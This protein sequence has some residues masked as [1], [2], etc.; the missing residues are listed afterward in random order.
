MSTT[1]SSPPASRP[2]FLF[3]T[4]AWKDYREQRAIWLAI[5]VL[6]VVLSL[7]IGAFAQ[8]ASRSLNMICSLLGRLSASA[9]W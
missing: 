6:A 8:A 9:C 4:L 3:K 1:I 7:G 2:T 5:A